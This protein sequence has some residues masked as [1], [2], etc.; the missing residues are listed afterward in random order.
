[1]DPFIA[2]A[3]LREVRERPG[4]SSAQRAAVDQDLAAIEHYHFSGE[5]NGQPPPDLR[6]LVEKWTG[7]ARTMP[8]AARAT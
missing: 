2:A 4:L 5:A 3:L 7:D 1:L 6:A 8:V